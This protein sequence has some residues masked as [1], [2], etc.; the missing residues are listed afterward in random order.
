MNI[1][2][3]SKGLPALL[4]L[5][6]GAGS[7][8]AQGACPYGVDELGDCRKTPAPALPLPQ[9]IVVESDPP[10]AR[11]S[12]GARMLGVTPMELS[13]FEPGR[14]LFTLELDGYDPQ[15]IDFTVRP[16]GTTIAPR[17][18]LIE[19]PKLTVVRTSADALKGAADAIL[20]VD[21]R[22]I[23]PL[24]VQN[25]HVRA[26]RHSLRVDRPGYQSWLQ[27]IDADAGH[28][29]LLY[30]AVLKRNLGYLAVGGTADDDL[31]GVEVRLRRLSAA[32]DDP[33]QGEETL[34]VTPIAPRQVPPGRYQVVLNVKGDQ[35]IIE[36]VVMFDQK[37]TVPAKFGF[38]M[39]NPKRQP[40]SLGHWKRLCNDVTFKD[41]AAACQ[42]A[43]YGFLHLEA[44]DVASA[45]DA[46]TVGCNNGSMESCVGQGHLLRR[47]TLNSPSCARTQDST[48][49]AALMATDAPLK[50]ACDAGKVK[51]CQYRYI[52]GDIDPTETAWFADPPKLGLEL[53]TLGGYLPGGS[54]PGY[55]EVGVGSILSFYGLGDFLRF[56]LTYALRFR[57][58]EQEDYSKPSHPSS[59]VNLVGYGLNVGV[60]GRPLGSDA[61][62]GRV[63]F[64]WSGYFNDIVSSVGLSVTVGH[65]FG[66]KHH[67]LVDV[68]MI[69]ETMPKRAI[70]VDHFGTKL[71]LA[72]RLG[73]FVPCLRYTYQLWL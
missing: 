23:G 66:D 42:A 67:H 1:R 9:R 57:T 58:L 6:L 18:K 53:H 59:R 11:V 34:G 37:V 30:Q 56:G 40:G 64:R 3:V 19:Q 12:S 32:E 24:P 22:R 39:L 73:G 31:V 17:I 8:F 51:A 16:N 25:F 35:R 68:G 70:T 50:T 26:G 14:Q 21:D 33:P 5:V 44:P 36:I 29:D 38:N 49:T 20:F 2:G 54:H 60:M 63:E 55:A 7:A 48:C 52:R 62:F 10:G 61:L 13:A 46:Y 71:I 15:L 28:P 47:Q 27:E 72:D 43:G 69:Y 45:K 41:R 4:A 65:G